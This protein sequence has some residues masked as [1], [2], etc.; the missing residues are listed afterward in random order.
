MDE[1]DLAERI[2]LGKQ[3]FLEALRNYA[4]SFLDPDAPLED[5]DLVVAALRDRLAEDSREQLSRARS[6]RSSGRTKRLQPAKATGR[7]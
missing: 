5:V 4:R 2:R 1:E 3:L 6:E 7:R